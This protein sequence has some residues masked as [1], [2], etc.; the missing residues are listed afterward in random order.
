MC[1]S[2]YTDCFISVIQISHG[3]PKL[4][5]LHLKSFFHTHGRHHLSKI[6]VTFL[7]GLCSHWHC[8]DQ[9]LLLN[10]IFLSISCRTMNKTQLSLP[11][12]HFPPLTQPRIKHIGRIAGVI[13]RCHGKFCNNGTDYNNTRGRLYKIAYSMLLLYNVVKV[14]KPSHPLLEI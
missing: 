1:T 12:S 3:V 6:S 11:S 7:V 14:I 2:L 9:A 8:C 13:S 10:S 5:D 4:S